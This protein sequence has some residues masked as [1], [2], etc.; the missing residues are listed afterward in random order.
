MDH[1]DE[2]IKSLIDIT[3]HR[4][5]EKKYDHET[6]YAKETVSQGMDYTVVVHK[7]KRS[8]W[9]QVI[10]HK[11]EE[12]KDY[13]EYIEEEDAFVHEGNIKYMIQHIRNIVMLDKLGEL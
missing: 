6:E 1:K 3:A 7:G 13:I 11:E 4:F 10:D 9:I 12:V 2:I 8:T 5:I